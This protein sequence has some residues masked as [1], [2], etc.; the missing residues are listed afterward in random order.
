M[1]GVLE[2]HGIVVKY[3]TEKINP[4]CMVPCNIIVDKYVCV[5]VCDGGN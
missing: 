1:C 2:K 3:V 5:C 4:G